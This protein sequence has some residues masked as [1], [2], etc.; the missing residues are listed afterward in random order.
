MVIPPL[1]AVFAY[2]L[3][4]LLYGGEL[5]YQ[6]LALVTGCTA[7]GWTTAVVHPFGQRHPILFLWYSISLVMPILLAE[8]LLVPV[9]GR[10]Y[11]RTIAMIALF[12]IGAIRGYFILFDPDSEICKG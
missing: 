2:L 3:F 1:A 4:L 10:W 5:F 8:I 9:G 11:G 12:G 6:G 7:L